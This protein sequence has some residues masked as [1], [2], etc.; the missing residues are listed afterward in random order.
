[1]RPGNY[2]Y[3]WLSAEV[4]GMHLEIVLIIKNGS[5]GF[6]LASVTSP[7]LGVWLGLQQQAWILSFW[8]GLKSNYTAIGYPGKKVPLLLH[9]GGFLLGWPLMWFV[10]L[11]AGQAHSSPFSFGSLHSI[12]GCYMEATVHGGDS[13]VSSWLTPSSPVFKMLGWRDVSIVKG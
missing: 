5:S 3:L 11:K 7:A 6:C 12:F 8:A 9:F 2:A 13:Q 10:G 4:F 1:M